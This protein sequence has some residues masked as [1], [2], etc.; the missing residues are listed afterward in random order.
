MRV[1]NLLGMMKPGID[2][3]FVAGPPCWALRGNRGRRV[4][5]EQSRNLGDPTGAERQRAVGINNHGVACKGVGEAHSSEET[6]NHRGA[7]G[8]YAGA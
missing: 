4:S 7:K 6:A 8:L 2:R 1:A 3:G 5:K